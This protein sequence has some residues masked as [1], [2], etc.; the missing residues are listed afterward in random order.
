MAST[1]IGW[2]FVMKH[3]KLGTLGIVYATTTVLAL[4]LIGIV[5][6]KETLAWYEV[7]GLG[8]GLLSILLLTRFA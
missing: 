2:F 7:V 5:S 6:F 1:A 8:A 4:T 3:I